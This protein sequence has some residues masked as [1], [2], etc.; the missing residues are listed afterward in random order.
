LLSIGNTKLGGVLNFSIPAQITCPGASQWCFIHCYCKKGAILWKP[1]KNLHGLNFTKSQG[2]E[3]VQDM[4][5]EL[6]KKK[7]N[8]VRIHVAGDFYSPE[9]IQKWIKIVGKS[10]KKFFATTKS[11]RIPRLKEPLELLR[12]LPNISLKASTDSTTEPAPNDWD[13][14]GIGK[15]YSS[16]VSRHCTYQQDKTTCSDCR[17]CWDKGMNVVLKAH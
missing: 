13:E 10:D 5:G 7:C 9:Y 16:K 1:A 2:S 8:L 11:W 12:T 6:D 15:T 4:L 3:F 14:I 17:L